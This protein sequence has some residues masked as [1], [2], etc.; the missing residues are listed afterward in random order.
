MGYNIQV[1]N[2]KYEN[3]A[4]TD[5]IN[6]ITLIETIGNLL[7][8]FKLSFRDNNFEKLQYLNELNPVTIGYEINNQR[9]S[10][11]FIIKQKKPSMTDTEYDVTVAGYL[12]K[13]DYFKGVPKLP[14]V[15]DTSVNAM[16]Q[17]ASQYFETQAT[18]L[19]TD[20]N[21]NWIHNGM[22]ARNF[23][24]DM[25][26]HSYSPD[27]LPI[28]GIGL[29]GVF[30]LSDLVTL[31]NQEPK[32]YFSNNLQEGYET[33]ITA[34]PVENSLE[35]TSLFGYT[36]ERDII[37]EDTLEII[38]SSQT[39]QVV[40]NTSNQ[41]NEQQGM[42][43]RKLAPMFQSSNVHKHWY[44]AYHQNLVRWSSLN[45]NSITITL[46]NNLLPLNILDLVYV[47]VPELG[48][49]GNSASGNYIISRKEH[50]FD[51]LGNVTSVFKG[52]RE[53]SQN[54]NIA[55]EE[56]RQEVTSYKI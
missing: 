12:N 17:V 9:I 8:M 56:Q 13:F 35:N 30:R 34:I 26:K 53:V 37:I 39:P 20:D 2:D 18:E 36:S 11:Q 23:I 19:Q 31:I 27:S 29:D 5:Q 28:I 42:P 7:P 51:K 49:V 1:S 3:L 10:N 24:Q 16:I 40:L 15:Q 41:L 44:E 21:M 32:Y 33:Y 45:N 46:Y 50:H 25:W 54:T 38:K 48:T 47:E 4:Y 52:I 22:N 43:T 14:F 6:E 55:E